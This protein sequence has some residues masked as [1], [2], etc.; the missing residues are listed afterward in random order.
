MF[1]HDSV[2]QGSPEGE[3]E[4]YSRVGNKTYNDIIP[5]GTLGQKSLITLVKPNARLN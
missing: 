1:F 2:C 4:S 3:M 5:A